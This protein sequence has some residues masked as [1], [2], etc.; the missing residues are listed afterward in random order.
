MRLP[1]LVACVP[2][3]LA[4]VATSVSPA[5]ASG[6][7][8]ARAQ[9]GRNPS[10][11]QVSAAIDAA[12][13]RRQVPPS[14]LK[15]IAWKESGWQQFWSDGRA[16]VSGDCGVGIMQ[17]TGG[18]WD[19]ARLGRDYAYNIDAGA[20]ALAAKMSQ[21]SANVPA[22]LGADDKRVLEN[23]YR[24]TYRYNGSGARAEGYVDSVFRYIAAPPESIRPYSPPIPVSNPKNVISGY[25][26]TSGHGY[27]AHLDG[28]WS[29]TIGSATGRVT[30]ADLLPMFAA[31]T[32]GRTLEG[33]QRATTSYVV[34][35]LGWSAWTPASVSVMTWPAGR[36]SALADGTWTSATTPTALRAT[37]PS[38]GVARVSFPVQA[39][40]VSSSRSVQESF[41]LAVGGRPLP[42]AVAT[43]TWQLH[44][45]GRPTAA[46]TASPIYTLE[47]G[48]E[49]AATVQ[50]AASDPSPGAGLDRVEISSRAVCQGCAWTEPVRLAPSTFA[51]RVALRGAGGHDLRVRAVDRAGNYGEWSAAK[52]VVVP[53]DNVN[54]DVA[55][56]ANW[57][58]SSVAGS[59]MGSV[60]TTRRP[61]ATVETTADGTRF[62]VIGATGPD[63]A[64]LEVWM[65]GVLTAVV[66]PRSDTTQ[67]RQVLWEGNASPG[68]HTLRVRVA[69]S[70]LTDPTTAPVATV[71][72]LA[73]G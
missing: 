43:S 8:T 64:E 2:L 69:G 25:R 26:P 32:A 30:R 11:A 27:V 39:A 50:L 49:P 18:S 20:Q 23:W 60:H 53:R 37:V 58:S 47:D 44:P 3:A 46:I 51:A 16:K 56:D 28:R 9:T 12:A 52:R 15:A 42:S 67:Q 63:V 70:A 29:S 71:D 21:S 36:E 57:A 6:C 41:T 17:I 55:F 38:G 45:L 1:R 31:T 61:G 14:L 65:D 34:R 48:G 72:A 54:S 68:R 33:G 13:Q 66:A 24:G 7:S 4:L 5:L 22:G 19:Y 62:A 35:N 40:S 10:F 73:A 59:W